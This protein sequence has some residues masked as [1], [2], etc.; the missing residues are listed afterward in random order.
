MPLA[1]SSQSKLHGFVRFF[2]SGI[3]LSDNQYP[4]PIEKR[5]TLV[6][7][8]I[9]PFQSGKNNNIAQIG[10]S[11]SGFSETSKTQIGSS[12]SGIIQ[13]TPVELSPDQDT[14]IEV[15]ST[16]VGVLESSSI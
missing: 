4:H 7:S 11:E 9:F 1:K 8:E 15:G 14:V 3:P 12:E 10:S 13:V 5:Y 6:S 16:Q 2:V